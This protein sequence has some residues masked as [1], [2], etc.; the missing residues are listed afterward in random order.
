MQKARRHPLLPDRSPGA[1]APTACR[2]T[3][4]G[5]ISLPSQGFFSPFPHGTGSLSV[6]KEYLALR[7]G[8]R[9]FPQDF[10]CPVVLRIPG[11]L[12]AA[13]VYRT[14]TFCGAAFQPASTSFRRL[15]PGPSTPPPPEGDSGLGSFR[16]ARRYSGNRFFFL[17]LQVLRWFTSLSSLLP[18]YGFSRG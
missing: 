12:L 18:T 7:D 17:F 3:V 4:S 16:F 10:A 1:W 2:Q 8:P 13:F 5:T 6:A 15:T 11:P 9:R 14:F